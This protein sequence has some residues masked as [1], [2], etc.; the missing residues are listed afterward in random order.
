M[1][2]DSEEVR[3]REGGGGMSYS[4]R[5]AEYPG[6]EDCPGSFPTE[7]EDELWRHIEL[8]G[9]FHQEDPDA[10]TEEERRQIRE[11]IRPS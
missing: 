9:A 11:L 5:C 1:S 6:M 10:W 8:H 4:Y 3:I 2:S 7:T